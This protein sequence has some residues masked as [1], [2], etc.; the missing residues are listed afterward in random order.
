[1]LGHSFRLK[2]QICRGLAPLP[3]SRTINPLL[4]VTNLL[5]GRTVVP[6]YEQNRKQISRLSLYLY[7]SKRINQKLAFRRI[8]SGKF[9]NITS[10]IDTR[11]GGSKY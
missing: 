6:S 1:M 11:Q 7:L 3:P 10:S 5:Y 9:Q 4:F 8:L 2:H